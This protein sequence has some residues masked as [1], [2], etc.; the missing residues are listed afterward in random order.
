MQNSGI[1]FHILKS[2]FKSPEPSKQK[3]L[4]SQDNAFS[5]ETSPQ[6]LKEIKAIQIH[7]NYLV[8]DIMAGE[9]ETAFKG[10]GMEFAEVRKYHAG[11]D[12][13]SIDW[14]V[15]ARMGEPYVKKFRDERELTVIIMVDVSSSGHFGS[16]GKLKNRV[17]AEVA[18]TI[19]FLAIKNHDKV[20]LILFSNK[21]EQYIPPKK[22]KAHI[23]LVI[24]SILSF[25]KEMESENKRRKTDINVPLQFLLQVQKRKS[26][27]FLISDFKDS[28][29][30]KNLKMAKQK[31]DLIAVSI[32]DP[33][34]VELPETGLVELE[35]AETGEKISINTNNKVLNERFRSLSLKES[36]QLKK[37]LRALSIDLIDI[38]TD[39]P[40]TK[41]I[42]NFFKMRKKRM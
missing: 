26:V 20:G 12:V 31:H 38:R 30:E 17:A 27:S 34:E 28:G 10:R 18:S 6:F 36:E 23:W 4:S 5:K 19:A 41:A 3:N 13:R 22:G 42:M 8:N 21:I 15:T 40:Y 37:M 39:I 25:A 1:M 14:N 9:Y 35:D 29:Y 33:R 2:F 16:E 11:D 24:K 32:T 7:T